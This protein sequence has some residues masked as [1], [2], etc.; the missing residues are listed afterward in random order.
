[1]VGN[2]WQRIT[3]IASTIDWF[4]NARV[5]IKAKS[6]ACIYFHIRKRHSP[7]ATPFSSKL[8][9]ASSQVQ[10]GMESSKEET[11]LKGSNPFSHNLGEG[12]DIGVNDDAAIATN[13]T[14]YPSIR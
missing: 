6:G 4:K 10:S 9:A 12:V 2:I 5:E 11:S 14:R 7:V 8:A 13:T 3:T 1:M